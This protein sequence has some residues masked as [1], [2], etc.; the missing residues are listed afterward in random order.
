MVNISKRRKAIDSS[1]DAEK[2]YGL[3][4]AAALV[5][6]CAKAKFDETVEVAVRLGVNPKHADQMVR[7]ALVLPH[8]TGLISSNDLGGRHAWI[9]QH[10]PRVWGCWR[11]SRPLHRDRRLGFRPRMLRGQPIRS[12]ECVR[13]RALRCLDLVHP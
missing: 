9:S 7:G 1:F 13:R 5:K 4:E 3:D 6:Q 12:R 2:R 11:S 8:G 10:S